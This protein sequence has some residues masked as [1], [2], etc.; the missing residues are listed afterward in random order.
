MADAPTS[1]APRRPSVFGDCRACGR[2]R[3]VTVEGVIRQHNRGLALCPGSKQLPATQVPPPAHTPNPRPAP[4][5]EPTYGQS[6]DGGN[7]ERPSVGW[8]LYRDRSDWLPVCGQHMAG[9][10]AHCRV[11]DPPEETDG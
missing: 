7:C 4:P 8:R 11:Y 9:A 5:A 10:P 3:Q 1:I 2:R 6:C